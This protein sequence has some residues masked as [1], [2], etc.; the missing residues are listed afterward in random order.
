MISPLLAGIVDLLEDLVRIVEGERHFAVRK[1]FSVLRAVENN[2]LH[3]RSAKG[4]RRLF[5]EHPTDR[6]R[7]VALAATV[8]TDDTGNAVFELNL[9]PVGERLKTDQLYLFKIHLLLLTGFL[10]PRDPFFS[11]RIF[12]PGFRRAARNRSLFLPGRAVL[13]F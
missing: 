6:V 5:A 9:L 10:L 7:N 12:P 11:P 13:S 2:V 4:F 8:R 3:A 1:G